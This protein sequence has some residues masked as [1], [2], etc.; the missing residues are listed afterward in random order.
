MTDSTLTPTS[1]TAPPLVS[2]PQVP[3]AELTEAEAATMSEWVKQDLAGGKLTPEQA[4]KM[5]DE[6]GRSPEQRLP[7]TRTDEQKDLDRAFPAAKPE[8]YM[9]RYG[10]PGQE[11]RMTP[12][13][14]QFDAN[15]RGWMS[16]AGLPRETGNS[17]VAVID[18]V[19][20]QT[21]HMTPDQLETYRQTELVK[22]QR[23]HGEKLGERLQAADDMI[24]QLESRRPRLKNLLGSKGVGRNSMIWNLLIAH[25]QIYHARQGR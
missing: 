25:A 19:A 6:L 8:D 3:Q 20:Q 12:E 18:R 17:L 16:D 7:D 14:K 22:L 1:A 24:D 13:L 15:A 9:I 5:F 10:L 23:A 4:T 2:S 21:Q 11:L